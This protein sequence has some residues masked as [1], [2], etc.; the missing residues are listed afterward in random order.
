MCRVE[1]DP[2]FPIVPSLVLVRKNESNS[3]NT[4]AALL[5]PATRSVARRRL[6]FMPVNMFWEPS[7]D[8]QKS[9]YFGWKRSGSTDAICFS[10]GSLRPRP[11][12]PYLPAFYI[13]TQHL[14]F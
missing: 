3:S 5:Y 1:R 11:E 13:N 6:R 4:L 12:P 2:K 14:G 10:S 9:K 8:V 7:S